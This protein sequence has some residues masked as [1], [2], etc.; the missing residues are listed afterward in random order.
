[1]D[2]AM[3]PKPSCK[4]NVMTLKEL[5]ETIPKDQR[6][7]IFRNRE[8][9]F[10]GFGADIVNPLGSDPVNPVANLMDHCISKV[11]TGTEIRHKRWKEN[12]YT[13]PMEPDEAPDYEFKDLEQKTYLKIYI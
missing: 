2:E 4:E 10:A 11:V 9:V 3:L 8:A 7:C 5:V 12:G 6:I 13:A 1:M